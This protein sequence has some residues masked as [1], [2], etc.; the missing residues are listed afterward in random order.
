MPCWRPWRACRKCKLKTCIVKSVADLYETIAC[1]ER[2][3]TSRFS[4]CPFRFGLSVI[5]SWPLH[6]FRN[7]Q[8]GCFVFSWGSPVS[9]KSK[10]SSRKS[11]SANLKKE[12]TGSRFSNRPEAQI[13][14]QHAHKLSKASLHT[15]HTSTFRTHAVKH[16]RPG[17]RSKIKFNS[18]LLSFPSL[19]IPPLPFP[20]FYFIFLFFP[21]P[22]LCNVG[23]DGGVGEG[24]AERT[25]KKN[26]RRRG[27]G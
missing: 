20:P 13:E 19:F 6:P 24:S 9:G 7:R 4:P 11:N 23:R 10:I 15:S 8:M 12:R 18:P 26:R 27:G 5:S 14:I 17:Q 21:I 1:R 25:A 2:L 16:A 22:V 3:F